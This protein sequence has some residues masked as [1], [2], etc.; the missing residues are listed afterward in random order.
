MLVFQP[1]PGLKKGLRIIL[2]ERD[3]QGVGGAGLSTVCSPKSFIIVFYIYRDTQ[4]VR[5][6]GGRRHLPLNGFHRNGY[7]H[8]GWR[9]GRGQAGGWEAGRERGQ[10]RRRRRRRMVDR[11][12][13]G[14]YRHIHSDAGAVSD[15][16]GAGGPE[17]VLYPRRGCCTPAPG[18][19]KER[20]SSQFKP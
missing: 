7:R 12:A 11:H 19:E 13:P 16:L 8:Y 6:A 10:R 2:R 5:G 1:K 15:D 9:K 17:S 18:S 3:A 14:V 20:E 4:G